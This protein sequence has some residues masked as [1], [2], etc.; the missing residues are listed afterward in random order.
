MNC[1]YILYLGV[2]HTKQCSRITP[3]SVLTNY[4]W[5]YPMLRGPY[6]MSKTEPKSLT[7]RIC[8]LPP[9]L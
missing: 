7:C 6:E 9:I 3:D 2:R 5:R 8:T 1:F 4:S